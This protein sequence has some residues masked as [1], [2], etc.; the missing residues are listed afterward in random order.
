MNRIINAFLCSVLL[1]VMSVLGAV[2][3]AH[4]VGTN[5]I[6]NPS[7]ETSVSGKP[8]SWSSDTWG[9]NTTAFTYN[10]TGHTGTHSL[11]TSITKYTSGDS[12]WDF[13]PV[14]VTP[15]TSYTFSDWYQ[16]NISTNVD[17]VVTNT[18]GKVSY[19]WLANPAASTAWK[20]NTYTFTTPANAAKVAVY[21]SISKV[22]KLTVDDYSLV[23]NS[24]TTPPTAPTVSVTAP[25]A[26]ASVTG[27]TTLT[28]NASDAVAVSSVQ[29]K[30]DGVNVGAADTT[31]PYSISWD[32]KTVANGTHTV[33]AV[34]TNSSNLTTTSS[35]V[36][37]TVANPT[38]PTVSV[39]AP[40]ASSTVTGA[41]T[42][43]ANASDAVAVSSVQFKVDGV[44]VGAA[45]TTSPYSV[46]WDSKTVTNGTHTVT[47]VATNSSNLTTTSSPVTITVANVTPPTAPTVSITSPTTSATVSNTI[48]V[49]ATAS[50]TNAIAGVQFK[51]D[52]VNIGVE[53]TT[54]PY[55]VSLD[56]KTT[57][58]GSHT[59]S[60]VARDTTNLT[61][62]ASVTVNVQN[63]I[64]PT[65]PTVS[66]TAPVA[67][68]SV[69]GTTTLTA[70]A[71]DAVAVSSVQ[72]K[73]DGV[74][75]GAADTTS[76]Y[77]ISW[78]SKTVANGT[79]TV[80][81][82]ATNSSNLTTTSSPVTITVANPTAPTVS[83]TAPAAS[84]TVTGATTLTANASDAVAVSSVQFKVDGVNVGA[85]DTTSPYS[86]S[87]DSKT[88]TNGTHTV[89]AVAT[90]SSNLTTTSS[91]V[92]I[93][94]SNTVT[95]P[96][97]ANLIA[98]PSFETAQDASTP[99]NWIASSWGNNT[100]T[101]SYLSTGHTGSR[102]VKVQTTA[103]TDGA[104][105]WSYADVPV[106][107][108]KT[109]QYSNWYQSNVDTEVDAEVTLTNGTVQ[110]FWLGTVFANTNWTQF[111]T[112]FTPPAGAKSVA[113]YQLLAKVGYI[114]SDDYSLAEY[115]PV[116]YNRGIVSVNFDD[117]WT[118][119]Y[120]NANPVLKQLGI[121]ATYFI[122]SGELNDTPDYMTSTQ[123]KDLYANGNEI[124]SHTVTHPDLTTLSASQMQ[125]EM[126]NSQTTLQNLIGAPVTDFAYPYG[127]YNA[128]TISVG[129][130]YYAS[131][132]SV[133]GG[134]NTK[135]SLD[136][137][138]L[139]IEE[140]DSDISQA[141]VQGWINAAVA[142]HA[143][144]ILVYHEVA[145]TPSAADDALYTTQPSDF[146]AEMNYLKNSGVAVETTH[147]ALAEVQAQ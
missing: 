33:T 128:N 73:V 10:S 116:P 137:T 110:Y 96:A 41:T 104:A 23:N 8:T 118:N 20:Q 65:A 13:T 61:S 140:V 12:K 72:F 136:V 55:S 144:L 11:T 100:S 66:V 106:T 142:Q 130:Q 109:Y 87:W 91:P 69:T 139:K 76:P 126:A 18:T 30:V 113:I 19:I 68:A 84:S 89:T 53:D 1:L 31:S 3:T 26:N 108:G 62:T 57:T 71:S 59:L 42:L 40:A 124:G 54:S 114:T 115:T 74:N 24:T 80:T 97:G 35:P 52:G 70:N 64:P 4:A 82:V 43:T 147:Q 85:A 123:V 105:N 138:Q 117:G 145:T 7:A 86:V 141:Q 88:V 5:L 131:Q 81:A 67:N 2:A 143:W 47:A 101:F 134:L 21:N 79:H 133:N 103:Y 90:N 6:A 36:T 122:I 146:T 32:S 60:A 102:S 127:A 22:G 38:A 28:A 63:V 135:D 78:D 77:S 111:K 129:K 27:T 37:I 29:F 83:V 51:L 95:P 25:V 92:T 49:A 56:T 16:S 39:T 50:G 94:V 119:Q 14:V 34:A 46:S 120:L 45:D 44:N 48:T 17:L 112:T 125:S 99:A 9:T 132:R 107:V 93:T 98:N 121:M 75:V 58:N 15:N